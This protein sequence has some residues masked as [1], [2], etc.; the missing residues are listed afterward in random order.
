[1]FKLAKLRN[2]KQICYSFIRKDRNDRSGLV[3]KRDTNGGTRS[4]FN[5]AT[6][7]WFKLT[8][9]TPKVVMYRVPNDQH[10]KEL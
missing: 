2:K 5:F 4:E 1:M 9:V 8:P 10:F 3:C 6:I 7:Y